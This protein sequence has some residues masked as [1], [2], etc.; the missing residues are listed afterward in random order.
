M[1]SVPSRGRKRRLRDRLVLW[2][3]MLQ[4][5][6]VSAGFYLM[7]FDFAFIFWILSVLLP[8]ITW[9]IPGLI[10]YVRAE[11]QRSIEQTQRQSELD[12]GKG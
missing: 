8:I 7:A 5:V 10:S 6:V 1:T 2:S 11:R 12:S 3:V 4:L 9:V